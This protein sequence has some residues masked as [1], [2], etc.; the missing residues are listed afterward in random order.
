LTNVPYAASFICFIEHLSFE[1]G[2]YFLRD[3]FR[4]PRQGG[5]MRLLTPDLEKFAADYLNRD[6]AHF[7]WYVDNFRCRTW[8]EAFNMGM[9]AQ[10]FAVSPSVW[11]E[12]QFTGNVANQCLQIYKGALIG[13]NISLLTH[14]EIHSKQ[15]IVASTKISSKGLWGFIFY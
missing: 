14:L 10:T 3:R 7:Q 15:P 6:E 8:A 11:K 2:V 9:S 13:G 5:Y 4:V 12:S 1:K